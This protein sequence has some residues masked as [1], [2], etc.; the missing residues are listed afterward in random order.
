L[1][2]PPLVV[3]L[4]AQPRQRRGGIAWLWNLTVGDV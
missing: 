2:G 3:W 4:S 1:V